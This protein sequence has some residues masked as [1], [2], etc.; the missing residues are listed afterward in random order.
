MT[1]IASSVPSLVEDLRELVAAL[2]RRV[3][4][5]ERVG[6]RSIAR[7]AAALREQALQRIAELERSQAASAI[8]AADQDH[9]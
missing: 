4:L 2:D 5:L 1:A 8:A 7:D 3:P 6:E 9:A